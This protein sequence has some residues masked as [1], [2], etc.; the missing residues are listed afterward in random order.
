MHICKTE[1]TT[2]IFVKST[3]IRLVRG[4]IECLLEVY[5]LVSM[6]IIKRATKGEYGVW[7]RL[8][9]GRSNEVKTVKLIASKLVV[10]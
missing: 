6:A 4:P 7:S 10:I 1:L 9:M 2:N 3:K 5:F 8:G